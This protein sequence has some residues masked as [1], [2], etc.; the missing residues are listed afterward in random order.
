MNTQKFA[1]TWNV[2]NRRVA[3]EFFFLSDIPC[4]SSEA[5]L[6][7]STSTQHQGLAAILTVVNQ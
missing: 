6:A 3:D 1:R 2:C 7:L 5:L 4:I